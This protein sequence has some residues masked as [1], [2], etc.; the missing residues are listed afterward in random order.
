MGFAP[1]PIRV[2]GL[3]QLQAGL[4]AVEDG[5]QKEL[6]VALNRAAEIVASTARAGVP[7]RSGR[8]AATVKAQSGQR[9]AKVVGG[10]A[11]A[12]YYG[13]LDFGGRVGREKSVR[14]PFRPEGRYL[15][16]AWSRHRVEVLNVVAA[17][18]AALAASHGLEMETRRG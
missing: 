3:K 9:E 7:V 11:K 17:E 13:W 10:S 5:A 14:R 6:R 2:D 12:R 8:A 15:Y 1:D 18:L 16:P 4:K